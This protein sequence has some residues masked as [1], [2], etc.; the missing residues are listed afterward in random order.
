MDQNES[1]LEIGCGRGE[2]LNEF[3]EKVL[4]DMV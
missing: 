1:I 3:I 2:F 4:M